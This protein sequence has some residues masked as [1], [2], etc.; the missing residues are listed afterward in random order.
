MIS[1]FVIHQISVLRYTSA[2]AAELIGFT[3]VCVCVCVCVNFHQVSCA[4]YL[5]R[6]SEAL[7]RRL[8]TTS[9]SSRLEPRCSNQP[10]L[11]RSSNIWSLFKIKPKKKDKHKLFYS[12]FCQKHSLRKCQGRKVTCAVANI[13]DAEVPVMCR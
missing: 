4:A 11:A 5:L 9:I 1:S 7:R 10:N 12:S 3:L 2:T 13:A 8:R 6:Q